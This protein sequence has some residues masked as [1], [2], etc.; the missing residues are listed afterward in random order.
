MRSIVH[1]D[2]VVLVVDERV[3]GRLQGP[4]RLY[5]TADVRLQR[6]ALLAGGDGRAAF[7]SHGHRDAPRDA[8]TL[9]KRGGLLGGGET[10][11]DNE[12]W[13]FSPAGGLTPIHPNA[14]KGF[15]PIRIP[16]LPLET[17]SLK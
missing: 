4:Q 2:G 16:R 17:S 8:A 1:N 10:P 9:R 15:S 13:R 12:L 14:W 5:R 7:G 3:R 6:A 11:I